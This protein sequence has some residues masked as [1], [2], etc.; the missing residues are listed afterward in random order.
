MTFAHW[1]QKRGLIDQSLMVKIKINSHESNKYN[2]NGSLLLSTVN[3]EKKN[4]MLKRK[5]EIRHGIQVL[6]CGYALVVINYL[7][8]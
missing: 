5:I 7:V 3:G 6:C 4:C 8:T 2:D 1:A